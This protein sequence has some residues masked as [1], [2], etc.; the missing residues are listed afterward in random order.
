M[1]TIT[2]KNLFLWAVCLAIII[3]FTACRTTQEEARE[4]D[5]QNVGEVTVGPIQK[6]GE[7]APPPEP[8]YYAHTVR[9]KGETI[10]VIAGWY[11][12]NARNWKLLAEVN[13]GIKHKGLAAGTTVRVPSHI[14]KTKESMPKEYI[15]RFY[16]GSKKRTKTT[17]TV[18]QEENETALFGP[19]NPSR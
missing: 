5:L 11:T 7:E 3:Q 6:D 15:D 13:P 18:K 8:A 17:R 14:M 9:W 10:S 1:K 2:G 4:D 12:G 16:H 19:K